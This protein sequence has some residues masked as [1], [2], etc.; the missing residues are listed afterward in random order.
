MGLDCDAARLAEVAEMTSLRAM[1]SMPTKFDDHLVFEQLKKQIGFPDDAVHKTSKV[2][3]GT[4]GK[5][6]DLPKSVAEMLAN[7][8]RDTLEPKTNHSDYEALRSQVA[9]LTDQR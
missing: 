7:R 5:S 9:Q 8:W 6:K 3:T 2:Q 4:V 1:A